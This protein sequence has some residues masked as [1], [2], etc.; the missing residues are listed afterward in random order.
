MINSCSCINWNY[1]SSNTCSSMY[2]N[3]TLTWLCNPFINA[4][5]CSHNTIQKVNK[6]VADQNAHMRRLVCDFIVRIQKSQGLSR[7]GPFIG[8]L[9]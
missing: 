3:M 6:E 9:I 8:W 1:E 4:S 7:R 5:K 2:E